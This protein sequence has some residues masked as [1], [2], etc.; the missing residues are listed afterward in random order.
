MTRPSGTPSPTIRIGER[1]VGPGR[2]C[3]VVAEAGVNHNGDLEL[4]E[5]LIAES[6]KAGA[7]AVKFQSFRVSEL[8]LPD[9]VK[10]SYQ[11]RTSGE[12]ESQTAMLE[13][14]AVSDDFHRRVMD[15][16]EQHG[17]TYLSTPYDVASL[18]FLVANDVPAV[19]IASTD[20]NNLWFLEYVAKCNVPVIL[21]TGMT[22]LGEIQDAYRCLVDNGCQNLAILKCTSNYPTDPADVHLRAMQT[23][24]QIFP[25]PVGFSDHTPAVGASPYA[26]ALGACIIE[27]HL[28]L[29][30]S[31]PGPDH[32]ASMQPEELAELVKAVRQVENMLGSS[33]V[34][35][36]ATEGETRRALQRALVP[37]RALKKGD[38]LSWDAV[39]AKRTGG[40][41]I[42]A[43]HWNEVRDK[44]LSR[45]VELNVPLT[46]DAIE[47][48]G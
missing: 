7:D 37:R 42:A 27:K 9:V 46:W 25:V 13:R 1:V 39:T 43:A 22:T 17:V 45:D 19:K 44:K 10:A 40:R 18:D 41:G 23:L 34:G 2:P 6:A 32:A 20:A 12:A 15:L 47:D 31:M 8:I 21:S 5:R 28:T 36:T 4:A 35:P 14:L 48:P 33:M 3:L 24:A 29:D 11:T 30:R 26:V 38:T 16:C